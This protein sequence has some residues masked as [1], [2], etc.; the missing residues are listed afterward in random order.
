MAVGMVMMALGV[1]RFGITGSSYQSLTR[2]A[3]YRWS[4]AERVGRAP[5]MHYVGP[6]A[7]EVTIEGVI[8][9]HFKG[10]LRQV[11]LMRLRAGTGAPMMMVDGLGW[12]WKKWVIVRVEEKKSV[13]MRD[14]APKK[15]EFSI[16]LQAYGRDRA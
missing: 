4:K 1:F 12:I 2:S 16:T 6:D 14:G 11:E 5:A 15:I 13:F 3:G 8:Y 10:G 7:D 9:P